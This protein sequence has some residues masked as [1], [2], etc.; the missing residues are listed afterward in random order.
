MLCMIAVTVGCRGKQLLSKHSFFDGHEVR[1]LSKTAWE[2]SRPVYYE[3]RKSDRMIIPPTF[4][5]GIGDPNTVSVHKEGVFIFG[6]KKNVVYFM[7][8]TS[9]HASWPYRKDSET[10]QETHQK[11]E[12]MLSELQVATDE[13]HLLLSSHVG[14]GNL[15]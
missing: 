9:D 3:I 14:G 5:D 1:L 7:F 15:Q 13:P 10:I 2:Y 12:K 11:A 6:R 4:L 8:R